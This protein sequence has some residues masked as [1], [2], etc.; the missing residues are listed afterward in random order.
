MKG[1]EGAMQVAYM[2]ALGVV[3]TL[4]CAHLGLPE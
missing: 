4:M 3:L 1:V 2:V